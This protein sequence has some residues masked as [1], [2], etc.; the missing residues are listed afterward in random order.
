[1]RSI[2]HELDKDVELEKSER[3]GVEQHKVLDRDAVDEV[4]HEGDSHV[5]ANAL[6]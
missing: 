5:H 2:P 3:N 6:L 1:M 4:Q